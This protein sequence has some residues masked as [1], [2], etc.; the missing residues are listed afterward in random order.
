MIHVIRYHKNGKW[1]IRK[2]WLTKAT[3]S[4]EEYEQA[5]ILA[6]QWAKKER[7]S[8]AVY[9][10]GKIKTTSV[11]PDGPGAVT[12]KDDQLNFLSEII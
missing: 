11:H 12:L 4:F 1:Y 5:M 2:M 3:E 10:R 6:L 9:D 8:I 7:L